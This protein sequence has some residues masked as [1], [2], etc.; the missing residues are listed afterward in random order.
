[1]RGY[2][3]V[4]IAAGLLAV[5]AVSAVPAHAATVLAPCVLSVPTSKVVLRGDRAVD[6]AAAITSCPTQATSNENYLWWAYNS[7]A[8]NSEAFTFGYESGAIYPAAMLT[9]KFYSS[10]GGTFVFA[11]NQEDTYYNADYSVEYRSAMQTSVPTIVAKL[12]T[13]TSIKVKKS[14]SKRTLTVRGKRWAEYTPTM[15]NAPKATVY[16]NGKKYKT[17]KLKKG[18]ATITVKKSGAWQARQVETG[19]HWGSGSKTVTR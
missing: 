11:P 12:G 1:M 13:T 9:R 14:G 3:A 10:D 16:R 6:V 19:A 15:Q 2:F 17:V 5:S 4:T 8:T 7:S 18:K